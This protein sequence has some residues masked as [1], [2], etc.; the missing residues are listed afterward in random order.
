MVVSDPKTGKS[1]QVEVK[2]EDAR[3][4]IGLRI[5]DVFAGEIV[6]LPGK[7]LKITGGSDRSGF[8]M[9]PDL[10]GGALRRILASGPPG[11]RPR[12][13]GVRKRRTV[14][15][16]TVTEDIVQINAVIVEE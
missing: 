15:G 14:R 9:R 4:L 3:K 6:G 1:K 7:K 12:E 16:N 5:G 2:G 11:F 13:K 10:P 8:P